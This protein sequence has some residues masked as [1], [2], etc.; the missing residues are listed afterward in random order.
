MNV[1]KLAETD[2]GSLS[3]EQVQDCMERLFYT[4]MHMVGM[5]RRVYLPHQLDAF[6]ED[7]LLARFMRR[8]RYQFPA[9]DYTLE[10]STSEL[11]HK[12]L[13]KAIVYVRN[14]AERDE[15]YALWSTLPRLERTD[16]AN[17]E[18]RHAYVL[19]DFK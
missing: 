8:R 2:S 11:Q 13:W 12:W 1:K 6:I 7:R 9:S 4:K 18:R 14:R 15:F 10:D 19:S 3:R 17:H 16:C 5:E